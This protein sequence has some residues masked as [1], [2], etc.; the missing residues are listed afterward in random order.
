MP[1]PKAPSRHWEGK[2]TVT[3]DGPTQKTIQQQGSSGSELGEV[4]SYFSLNER[5]KA[6]VADATRRRRGRSYEALAES[7][8][9]PPPMGGLDQFLMFVFL[10]LGVIAAPLLDQYRSGKPFS[11]DPSWGFLAV[12]V[13][14]A[15]LITPAAYQRFGSHTDAPWLV[16]YGF[17]FQQGIF[18]QVLVGMI[19]KS[20]G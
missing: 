6:G 8:P 19:A 2:V 7:P 1:P 9:P 15:L 16:R 3:T 17:F 18:W 11:F 14:I 20:A 4:L 13:V 12:A 5:A 10:V